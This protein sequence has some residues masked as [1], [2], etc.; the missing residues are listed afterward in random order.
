MLLWAE[1]GVGDQLM[2]ARCFGPI[3]A[4]GAR[5]AFEGDARLFPLLAR[6]F[7][8]VEFAPQRDPPAP[9]LV[10]GPFDFHSSVLSAW[11]WAMPAELAA[12]QPAPYLVADERLAARYRDTWRRNG[13]TVNVGLSWRSKA[14]QLGDRKSIA[15]AALRPLLADS[16]LTFHSLQY[17]AGRDEL[18]ELRAAFGRPVMLD[19]AS[20]ALK[21][22]DRLAAQIKAL[23][24]VISISN[25]TVHLAGAMGVPCWVMLPAGSDWRWGESGHSTPLYPGMRLFRQAHPGDWGDVIARLRFALSDWQAA[26][27]GAGST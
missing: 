23:D 20:D 13:W 19:T 11:R 7:P 25:S 18:G 9:E 21:D 6:S 8:A 17:G 10:R 15:P 2:H 12:W 1:Q 24:L 14:P 26:L 22:L 27:P 4:S 16:R 3:L 5:V